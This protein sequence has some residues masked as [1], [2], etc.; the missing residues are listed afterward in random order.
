MP[1]LLARFVKEAD[2]VDILA[3]ILLEASALELLPLAI[4][5]KPLGV[6]KLSELLFRLTQLVLG[7]LE[8]VFAILKV[9]ARALGCC[10]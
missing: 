3:G 5:A 1:W 6:E 10:R 7:K 9:I 8:A 4:R 2:L